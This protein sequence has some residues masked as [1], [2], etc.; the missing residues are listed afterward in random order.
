LGELVRA[1]MD[2]FASQEDFPHQGAE[3]LH[4]QIE[5]YK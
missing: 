4:L 3:P 5:A 2:W 1:V